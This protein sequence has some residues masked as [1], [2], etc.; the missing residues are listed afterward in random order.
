MRF[1]GR[2]RKKTWPQG[3]FH[4]TSC[5]G[6]AQQG[7]P[8]AYA[9]ELPPRKEEGKGTPRGEGAYQPR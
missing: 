5:M 4:T 9:K 7:G 6:W 3:K 1:R 2:S 8:E